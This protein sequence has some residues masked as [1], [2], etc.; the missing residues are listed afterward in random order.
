VAEVEAVHSLE[1]GE[2]QRRFEEPSL[3]VVIRG[4]ARH[5]RAFGSWSPAYLQQRLGDIDLPHKV[6]TSNQ[7]PNFLAASLKETFARDTLPLSAFFE[8]ITQGDLEQRARR[9][10]TGDERFLVQRRNGL[11]H[12]D[13]ALAPLLEDLEQPGYFAAERLYTVWAWFSGQGVRT[14]LHYDNNGCHN[15]NAQITGRKSCVLFPPSELEAMQPFVLGGPNPAHN[16]SA[17]DI[18]APEVTATLASVSRFEAEIEAGDLLFIPA[19]WFHSFLHSG[20]FNSNVN[21]WWQPDRPASNAVTIRQG[22]LDAVVRSG[23]DAR[24]PSPARDLLSQLDRSLIQG[25]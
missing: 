8:A 5:W 3:P 15:L 24:T 10:F 1:I 19:H 13:E 21:F 14:W 25:H 20:Q 9:L 12:T 23:I 11:T 16:C 7:H 18:D 22:F 17:L 6:S 2:F 4:G